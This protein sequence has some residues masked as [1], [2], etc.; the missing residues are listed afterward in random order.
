MTS[1]PS[2]EHVRRSVRQILESKNWQLVV[3]A[4]NEIAFAKEV[5]IEFKR[6]QTEIQRK[7]TEE[8]ILKDAVINRYSHLWHSACHDGHPMQARALQEVFDYV[9]H[10]ASYQIDDEDNARECAQKALTKI[11]QN[12][13][14]VKDAGAFL[15]WIKVIVIRT[16][17]K[18]RLR[19]KR[20]IEIGENSAPVFSEWEI[21]LTD[22]EHS[23]ADGEDQVEYGHRDDTLHPHRMPMTLDQARSRIEQAIRSCLRSSNQQ[24]AVIRLLLDQEDYSVVAQELGVTLPN[25][26][27]LK[28][29]ALTRLRA[30]KEL[31]DVLDDLV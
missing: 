13:H 23:T 9:F 28:S 16:V 2:E 30:C 25:L 27:V 18:H 4:E 31:I 1:S 19:G 17:S 7:R 24:T 26:Y 8:Q 21:T 12:L 20:R 5:L 10:I 11:W 14:Q 3:G 22:L 15:Q 29:K 6:R